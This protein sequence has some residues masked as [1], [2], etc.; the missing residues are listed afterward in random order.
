[1]RE[2]NLTK[3]AGKEPGFPREGT[4]ADTII[5]FNMTKY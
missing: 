2:M 3:V 4:G 5:D 1:M